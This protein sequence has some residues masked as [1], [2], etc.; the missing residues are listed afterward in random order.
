VSVYNGT[1]AVRIAA[2]GTKRLLG[3]LPSENEIMPAA[4]KE[5]ISPDRRVFAEMEVCPLSK[6]K[7]GQM[8]FVCVESAKNVVTEQR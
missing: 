1:P 3:V 8:Q 4:M 2:K 7:R 6:R 5:Q